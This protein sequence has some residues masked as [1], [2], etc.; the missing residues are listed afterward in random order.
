MENNHILENQAH[1]NSNIM[2]SFSEDSTSKLFE[3]SEGAR[4]GKV[5]GH[6]TS[7][8][9]I[10]DS[11]NHPSHSNFTSKDHAQAGALQAKRAFEEH[12]KANPNSSTWGYDKEINA[13][14]V[15]HNK[16]SDKLGKKEEKE[17]NQAYIDKHV[18]KEAQAKI[19]ERM[20]S[21]SK[22]LAKQKNK[23]D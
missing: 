2:K 19:K 14:S 1:I 4:G 22:E 9:P 23:K 16:M 11:A 8:K 20:Q 7:G 13:H 12:R 21:V 18:S 10:Y 3:K 6:T 17:A 5:I 15:A